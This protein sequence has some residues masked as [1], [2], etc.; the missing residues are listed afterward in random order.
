[1]EIMKTSLRRLVLLF[2]SVFGLLFF[3]KSTSF[4]FTQQ[5][6]I[7]EIFIEKSINNG[8]CK[9][10]FDLSS[11]GCAMIDSYVNAYG[12]ASKIYL[13]IYLQKYN[14]N[15]GMWTTV[16]TWNKTS[17]SSLAVFSASYRLPSKGTYRCKMSVSVTRN[18]NSETVYLTSDSRYY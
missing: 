15:N 9:L 10:D 4:A 2:M 16:K 6:P 5:E 1:M 8:E 17:Y 13:C 7:D 14:P 12:N 11:S 18:G 3:M